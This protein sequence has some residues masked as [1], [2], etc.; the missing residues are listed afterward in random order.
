[1]YRAASRS[2]S[3]SM[4]HRFGW[5]AR[6]S[7][8]IGRFHEAKQEEQIVQFR[9]LLTNITFVA[10]VERAVQDLRGGVAECPEADQ[11]GGHARLLVF[12]AHRPTMTRNRAAAPPR[13][14]SP[15]SLEIPA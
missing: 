1:M 2:A 10:A 5:R 3:I 12:Q 8:P 4:A 14:D 13:F 6:A 15:R 7:V 9:R 11:Q